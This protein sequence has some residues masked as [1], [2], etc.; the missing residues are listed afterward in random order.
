M[1]QV[2]PSTHALLADKFILEE[3]GQIDVKSRGFMSTYRL[4]GRKP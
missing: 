3:R 2:S 1:I 4:V